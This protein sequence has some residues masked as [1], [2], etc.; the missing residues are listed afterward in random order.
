MS[1][2][3]IYFKHFINYDGHSKP[4]VHDDP[5]IM[6]ETC[7]NYSFQLIVKS[8]SEGSQQVAPATICNH[9]FQLIDAL[10]SEGALFAPY[11]FENA[12]TCANKLNCEGAWAQATSFLAS[13][14]IVNYSKISLH[15]QEDCGIFCE[16]EWEEKDNGNAL[17]MQRIA[18]I[19]N[20]GEQLL[21]NNNAIVKRQWSNSDE[22]NANMTNAI[23]DDKNE[24]IT[25]Q[26]SILPFSGIVGLIGHS[27]FDV[28]NDINS[29]IDLVSLSPDGFY[30]LIGFGFTSL[31]GCNGLIGL[32]KLVKLIGPVSLIGLISHISLISLFGN[33]GCN[34]NISRNDFVHHSFFSL[35]G[36]VGLIG[37][38]GLVSLLI[39][40]LCWKLQATTKPIHVYWLSGSL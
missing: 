22:T 39:N 33:I 11:I 40:H 16:G 12:F 29:L 7:T 13:K 15:F 32:V 4:F 24:V 5:A 20:V 37:I 17:I 21:S 25:Q 35:N 38:V 28:F 6:M 23:K 31:I 36:R 3:F 9:P 8:F 27:R 18:Y 10:A 14:L 26:Q 19:S 1:F 2:A 34:D 30:G